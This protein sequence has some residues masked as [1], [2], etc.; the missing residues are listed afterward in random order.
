[1]EHRKTWLPV[2]NH[3]VV[4]S[5]WL[6]RVVSS[7]GPTLNVLT[8]S[9]MMYYGIPPLLINRPKVLKNE[10]VVLIFCCLEMY[11]SNRCTGK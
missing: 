1:M 10:L 2:V 9:E 6:L 7:W 11:C 4:F 5:V 8:F 3:S